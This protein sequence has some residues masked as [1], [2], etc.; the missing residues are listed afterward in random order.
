[1]SNSFV[2]QP[3]VHTD[4]GVLTPDLIVDRL[5]I[6]EASVRESLTPIPSNLLT[7]ATEIQQLGSTACGSAALVLVAGGR[8]PVVTIGSAHWDPALADRPPLAHVVTAKPI[9][10]EA[11]RLNDFEADPSAYLLRTIRLETGSQSLVEETPLNE[12]C[13]LSDVMAAWSDGDDPP[14]RS[15]IFVSAGH[16]DPEAARADGYQVELSGAEANVDFRITYAVRRL[17]EPAP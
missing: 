17:Q 3:H 9:C 8:G 12:L 1:M 13:S 2:Y 11:L 4:D 15:A 7:T 5:A 6:L 16:R 14:A 10:R